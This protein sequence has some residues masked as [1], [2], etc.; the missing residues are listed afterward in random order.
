[1]GIPSLIKKMSGKSTSVVVSANCINRKNCTQE[2]STLLISGKNLSALADNFKYIRY[3]VYKKG[4]VC[5]T[6]FQ[7]NK[8]D[9][10][11]SPLVYW[12]LMLRVSTRILIEQYLLRFSE[13]FLCGLPPLYILYLLYMTQ[14]RMHT[15]KNFK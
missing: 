10:T 4:A 6:V 9:T 11:V 2:M 8:S 14:K 1:M 15:I 13:I 5:T 7:K 12:L 3:I